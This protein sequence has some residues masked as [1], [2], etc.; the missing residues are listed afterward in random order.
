MPMKHRDAFVLQADLL[1]AIAHPMRL[2][3]L[4]ILSHAGECCVCHLTAVLKQRQPRVS[5]HLMVLRS[6]GLVTDHRD[7]TLVYYRVADQRIG[8]F[9]ELLRQAVPTSDDV[10]FEIPPSPVEGCVCPACAALS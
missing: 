1:K 4:D 8:Q 10:H 2:C 6:K 3:I 5:Q 7:G 9:I